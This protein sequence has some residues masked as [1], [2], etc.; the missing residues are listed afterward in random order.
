MK[1]IVANV[2]FG[3]IFGCLSLANPV[4]A[5]P[6]SSESKLPLKKTSKPIISAKLLTQDK[7]LIVPQIFSVSDR[8]LTLD[9]SNDLNFDL[10]QNTTK[11]WHRNNFDLE[12]NGRRL[13]LGKSPYTHKQEKA[14][15]VLGFQNTFW[16]GSKSK[17]WGITTIEQWGTKK[18][19]FRK[20]PKQDYINSAPILS[21]GTSALTLSGG[22]KNNLAQD[23]LAASEFQQFRGGV[24]YHRGI[25]EQVTLGIGFVYEDL[26]V[27]FTQLTYKSNV[28]PVQT[29][30]SLL[31][32]ESGLDLH[33]HVR[34]QPAKNI[35]LNY[36]ND[37]DK[38]RFNADWG[39]LPGLNLIAQS[40]TKN[41]SF[42]TGI[43]L[44]I[45]SDFV[46]L[47]ADAALDNNNNLQWNLKSRIGGLK[48]SYGTNQQKST[49]D[50]SFKF[51]ENN[52]Y[53][54]QCSAF[55]KYQTLLV[56]QNTEEFTNWGSRITSATKV[57]KNKHKWTFDLGY[58]SGSY[59]KGLIVNSSIALKP[60][61]FLN[62]TYQEISP[63]SD[64]TKVK[65]M[66]SSK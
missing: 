23:A 47:S 3:G 42:S 64:D 16:P 39:V 1:A 11:L 56:K 2:L 66:L 57:S 9:Q 61:M 29:T 50:L 19:S 62:L 25:A 15:L 49:S 55:V 63:T 58:G 46:S 20:L 26:L 45:H 4:T 51:L 33:S 59:G 17:Y 52:Q 32:K 28:L 60:N 30:V 36:Y 37:Q 34:L 6:L 18:Q 43:K 5:N 13:S 22:G 12:H 41:K 24:T 40:N 14:N 10:H 54:F 7:P 8:I 27:G 21:A 65:L 44:A 38:Q 35:T 31:T 53:G 48:F